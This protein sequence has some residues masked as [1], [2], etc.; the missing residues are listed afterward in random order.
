MARYANL[1]T[2]L[3]GISSMAYVYPHCSGEPCQDQQQGPRLG[4]GVGAGEEERI[5]E[6]SCIDPSCIDVTQS[7]KGSVK[8]ITN[9]RKIV[10]IAE[11]AIWTTICRRWNTR[12]GQTIIVGVCLGQSQRR[13]TIFFDVR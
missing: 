4:D 9:G 11:F 13:K 5:D 1:T 3:A 10:V 8:R 7:C 6:V 12:R 2:T